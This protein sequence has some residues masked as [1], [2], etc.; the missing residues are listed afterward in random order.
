[1]KENKILFIILL[2]LNIILIVSLIFTIISINSD[3][4]MEK[5]IIYIYP[6]EESEVNIK[7]GKPEQ[8]LFS[9][10]KYNNDWNVIAKP[11]G[12]LTDT[13]TGRKLYSLYWEGKSDNKK[14]VEK[15]GFVIEGKDTAT[16]LEE[17]LATLGLNEKESEE[18]I[19]YWLPRLESNK[20]NYIRFETENE[21]NSNMPLEIKPEPETT[22]RVM[23]DF[24][25]LNEKIDV[26]EQKLTKKE[27]HGYTVV[28]WG[29]T[30]INN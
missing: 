22:I 2:I 15:E 5:P 6:K 20:Y 10:P 23:M 27:R 3:Y 14:E 13:K 17:K 29:G 28:E 25:S 24:K 26:Q 7:L 9:Y 11:N 16:F 19:I 4:I 1:M 18:F 12:D 8:L 21:I 30:E